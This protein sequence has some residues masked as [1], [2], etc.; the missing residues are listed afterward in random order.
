MKDYMNFEV[1]T[2]T[3][4]VKR[5]SH[6]DRWKLVLR[7]VIPVILGVLVLCLLVGCLVH[8]L[9]WLKLRMMLTKNYEIVISHPSSDSKTYVRVDGRYVSIGNDATAP[10]QYYEITEDGINVYENINGKGW[11]LTQTGLDSIHTGPGSG[12]TLD[13]LLDR[14]N[15]AWLPGVDEGSLSLRAYSQKKD[16]EIRGMN[17]VR[18]YVKDNRYVFS[19]FPDT[20]GQYTSTATVEFSSFGKVKVILPRTD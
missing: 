18:F 8:P 17:N 11:A 19:F 20:Q 4:Q 15:Y 1:P 6:P 5:H 14:K 12:T 7:I 16:A 13:E 2:D 3:N 10:Y 9:D